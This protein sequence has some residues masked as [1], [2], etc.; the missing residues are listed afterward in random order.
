[1]DETKRRRVIQL[2]HN[3]KHNITPQSIKKS[4]KDITEGIMTE[5]QKTVRRLIE[6]DK[7]AVGDS[8]K[9]I[10]KLIKDKEKEMSEAVKVLDFETAAL[11]R[12]E[13]KGLTGLYS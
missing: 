9:A 3:K 1:M 5:R 2:A 10:K 6:L 13:I 7:D 8:K 11:L 12:D 4:I